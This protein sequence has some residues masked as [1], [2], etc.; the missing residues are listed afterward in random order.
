MALWFLFASL[1]LNFHSFD[2]NLSL[3]EIFAHS[4]QITVFT[5]FWANRPYL[6]EWIPLT[7]FFS[8]AIYHNIRAS[9]TLFACNCTIEHW[10][11][12]YSTFYS[13][14]RTLSFTF[15]SLPYVFDSCC[16]WFC[17]N[18]WLLRSTIDV[19]WGRQ[20][21]YLQ[22]NCFLNL[23][24]RFDCGTR[25]RGSHLRVSLFDARCVC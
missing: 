22:A 24:F 15:S 5:L 25:V 17:A 8:L 6:F 19:C 4:S 21:R 9:L 7:F 18:T 3:R 2:F 20:W 16:Y 13:E 23:L 14:F 11:C 12:I 1:S 10:S